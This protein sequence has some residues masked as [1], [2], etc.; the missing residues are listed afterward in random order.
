[1]TLVSFNTAGS[2]GN[3]TSTSP[4]ASPDGRFVAFAS[5]ATD[6]VV[7]VTDN[8]A[9]RDVFLRDTVSGTTTLISA[10]PAGNVT[11]ER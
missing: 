9:T 3:D 11:G 10:T 7:G 5:V 2:A 4:D 8:N 1:M 6:L